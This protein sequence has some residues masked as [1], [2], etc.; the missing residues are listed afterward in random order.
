[1]R[2]QGYALT[3]VQNGLV[4]IRAEHGHWKLTRLGEEGRRGEE[5]TERRVGD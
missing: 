4:E 1:V 5:D 2:V 3:L